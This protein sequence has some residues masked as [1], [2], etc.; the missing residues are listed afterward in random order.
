MN[1]KNILR[2]F[3]K[4]TLHLAKRKFQ[5]VWVMKGELQPFTAFAAGEG[6]EYLA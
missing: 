3:A 2:N 1:E 4:T 6:G 5:V